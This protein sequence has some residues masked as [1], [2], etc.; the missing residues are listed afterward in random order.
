MDKYKDLIKKIKKRR[1]VVTVLSIVAILLTI[2][3]LSPTK[4]VLGGETIIDYEGNYIAMALIVV[5]I[6]LITLFAGAVAIFPMTSSMINECDPEKHLI[7]NTELNKAKNLDGILAMDHFYLGNFSVALDFANKMVS[8]AKPQYVCTGLFYK[9]RCEFF[10]NDF[11]S[12]KSTT[13]QFRSAISK[14]KTNQK[15][16]QELTKMQEVLELL[17]AVSDKDE[18]KILSLKNLKPWN[19]SKPTVGF[20]NYVQGLASMIVNDREEA[21]YRFKSTNE[22]CAKTVLFE[23]SNENLS[24][25]RI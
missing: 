1:T 11:D 14:V 16:M 6:L 8:S 18:Q 5:L 4:L 9:G 20:V 24:Q 19:N 17:V 22:I 12:L 3:L 23:L 2:F 13:E 7:L 15:T 25:L 21:I 10:L